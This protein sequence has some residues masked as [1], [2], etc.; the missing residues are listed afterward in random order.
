MKKIFSTIAVATA[1]LTGYSAYDAHGE[2]NIASITLANVE[3]LATGNEDGTDSDQT[4][5]VGSKTIKKTVQRTNETGWSWDVEGNVWLF[6]GSVSHSSPEITWTE[7][8]S[9][10]FNCCRQQ[11]DLKKCNYENC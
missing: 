11:G 8:E 10:T 1:L 3:A 5:Q 6:N 2:N 9:V 7:E 4:W